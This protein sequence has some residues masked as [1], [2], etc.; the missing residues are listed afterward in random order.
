MSARLLIWRGEDGF[1]AESAQAELGPHGLRARGVQVGVDPDA[2]RLDY[3]LETDERLVTRRVALHAE[4]D[5]WSRTLELVRDRSGRW[6]PEVEGLDGAEDGDLHFSPL[7][8]TMPALRA[9]L[10]ERDDA[11]DFTMAFVS[12]PDLSVTP[13]EQ[14]YEHVCRLEGGGAV[15]RYS[16][17]DFSSELTYDADGF[18]VDYPQIGSRAYPPSSAANPSRQLG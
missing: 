7:F 14:R 5:G 13:S 15:V 6:S 16:S 18:V 4:G 8:N 17:G 1:R 12:L 11:A 9:G 10:L 3:E 2:Y